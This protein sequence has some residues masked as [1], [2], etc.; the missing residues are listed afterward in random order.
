MTWVSWALVVAGCTQGTEDPVD[1]IPAPDTAAE[2]PPCDGEL[3][4]SPESAQV[5]PNSVHQLVP[6]GGSGTYLFSLVESVDWTLNEATGAVLVGGEPETATVELTDL[7]CEGSARASIEVVPELEVSPAAVTLAPGQGFEPTIRGGSGSFTC[8]LADDASGG[9]L[10]GCSYEA[11]LA[12][13]V[14]R[15]RVTD[16]VTGA[17]LDVPITVADGARPILHGHGR[18]WLPEGAVWAPRVEGGSGVVEIVEVSGKLDLVEGGIEGRKAGTGTATLRDAFL[19]TDLSVEVTVIEALVPT[20]SRDGERSGQGALVNA[21]DLD[22]DGHEELIVAMI[23]PSVQAWYGGM[24]ALHSGSSEGPETQVHQVWSGDDVQQTM[25]RAAA[26]ADV[27]GDGRA[28][29]LIGADRTDFVSTNSGIVQIHLGLGDGSFEEAPSRT[30]RGELEYGRFGT[31]IAACDFDGDGYVDIAVGAS[32]ASDVAVAD[33]ADDQGGLYLFKGSSSGFSDRAEVRLWGVQP[34]GSGGFEPE[35]GMELGAAVAAGDLD[36]DGLCDLVA[37]APEADDGRGRILVY[38]GDSDLLVEREP[39][40]VWT[41][42]GGALGRNLALGDVDDDG[43]LDLLAGAYEDDTDASNG[44]AAWLWYGGSLGDREPDWGVT[45]ATSSDYLG[46]DVALGDLNGDGHDEVVVAAHRAEGDH[47]TEGQVYAW[48]GSDPAGNPEWTVDGGESG[49]R[50]GQAIAVV[51]GRIVGLA[52]YDDT[53]GV[54]VGAVHVVDPDEPDEHRLLDLPGA[55]SGH[56]IGQTAALMDMD[57]DGV[58]ELLV[59]IPNMGVDGEGGN[60]GA[61]MAWEGEF[62]GEPSMTLATDHPSYSASDRY[63]YALA[64]T[65]FDG[66]GKPD[67]AVANRR[68]SQP[69]SFDSADFANPDECDGYRS[70]AGSVLIYRGRGA[71]LDSE[72]SWAWWAPESSG[73]VQEIAGGFDLDGDGDQEL[74]VGSE[75]W[76]D[77]GGVALLEGRSH[78]SDGTLVICDAPTLYGGTDFDRVGASV[79][80]VPDLDGDGC[81]EAAF[82]ATGEEVDEDY[83]NQGAVRI[84]WGCGGGMSTLTVDMV[85]SEGGSSLAAGDLD[86]DG[87]SELIVGA[88]SH[89]VAFGEVGAAWVSP[90]WYLASLDRHAL[91]ESLPGIEPSERRPLLPEEGLEGTHGILGEVAGGYLGEDVAFVGGLVAVGAPLA[92]L[93]GTARAGGVYLLRWDEGLEWPPWGLVVG[94]THLP[95]G[96][97]GEVLETDGETLLVG[98]PLSHQGGLHSGALYVVELP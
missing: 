2:A 23:E 33:P 21:G 52:G 86:G 35:A 45:G 17:Y 95:G 51:D 32:E 91:P 41:A 47:L 34:D 50:F 89:R 24:V 46:V 68:D 96:H 81:D 44:G 57:R 67:L 43:L 15:L 71:K 38:K 61:V 37:G 77:V 92:D 10:L 20:V 80:G 14:D 84:W 55:S 59:G 87:L 48:D 5:L 83:Y 98:A 94:E 40:G 53:Y 28:D 9:E 82:G 66:D 7:H 6:S 39:S 97:L 70:Y 26:V 30:L 1:G 74:L 93:G 4:I 12:E 27:D 62:T 64:V 72:P 13:G 42:S 54:E 69:T 56:L 88:T 19:G 73:E 16:P 76:Y 63:G 11:G 85:G 31:G 36:G 25:G 49:I 90:G 29:L 8:S 18:I 75:L 78:D 79:T 65:D 3:A 22:G 58:D 60:T